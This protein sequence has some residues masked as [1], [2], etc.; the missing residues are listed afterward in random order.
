MPTQN[1]RRA[2]AVKS[3]RTARRLTVRHGAPVSTRPRPTAPRPVDAAQDVPAK[4]VPAKAVLAKTKPTSATPAKER[5]ETRTPAAGRRWRIATWLL[6]VV[7]LGALGAAGIFAKQWYDHRQLDSAK[8][9]ALAAARQDVVDFVSISAATIDRDLK[10]IADNATGGFSDEFT[11][12]MSLVR[13][14]VVA[15]KVVWQ[16]TVLRAAVVSASRHTA[17]VLV[18]VDATVRNSDAPDGRLSHYRIEVT[19]VPDSSGRWLVSSLE[20]VG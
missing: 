3:A 13:S 12:D 10:R 17:V 9:Q 2:R 15:N 5:D 11:Q 1:D 19:L 7:L 18:A 4:A 16:G 20:F 8:Q 6:V 14:A